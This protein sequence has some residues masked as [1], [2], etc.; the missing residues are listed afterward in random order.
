MSLQPIMVNTATG[1]SPPRPSTREMAC[2]P[3]RF[4][5]SV[6]T[7][8][9][10]DLNYCSMQINQ[11]NNNMHD[12]VVMN[13]VDKNPA[14]LQLPS[15]TSTGSNNNTPLLSSL[16]SMVPI[17]LMSIGLKDG[18]SLNSTNNSSSILSNI[19]TSKSRQ[20]P[21][22]P[23]ARY[24]FKYRQRRTKPTYQNR[25]RHQCYCRQC[26]STSQMTTSGNIPRGHS[27]ITESFFVS[28]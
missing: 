15:P 23:P 1:S 19:N 12:V 18:Y 26:L 21:I 5:C 22:G 28:F 13:E 14:I 27:K 6:Q 9:S 4:D 11:E 7:S 3:I 10:D 24:N 25:R 2:S 17:P 16:S 8:R 20:W